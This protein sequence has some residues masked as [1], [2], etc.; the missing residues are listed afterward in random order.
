MWQQLPKTRETLRPRYPES[1][2]GKSRDD[3]EPSTQNNVDKNLKPAEKNILSLTE[4]AEGSGTAFSRG[5]TILDTSHHQ[6]LLGDWGGNDSGTAGSRNQT[7]PD[8]AAL[9]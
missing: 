3:P 5:V 9:A 2:P 4:V 6:K 1:Q 7:H 8:G